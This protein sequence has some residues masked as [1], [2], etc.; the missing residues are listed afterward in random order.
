MPVDGSVVRSRADGQ[1]DLRTSDW[2]GHDIPGP[3][4]TTVWATEEAVIAVALS[5]SFSGPNGTETLATVWLGPILNEC[6]VETSVAELGEAWFPRRWRPMPAASANFEAAA[7][8][9]VVSLPANSAARLSARRS[10]LRV[11]QRQ[12]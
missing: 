9:P 2:A 1:T 6:A 5:G 10:P 4:T 3:A 12:Q 7:V 8:A 11:F